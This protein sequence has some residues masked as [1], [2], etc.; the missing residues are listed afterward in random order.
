LGKKLVMHQ[1]LHVKE[2][3]Q[4]CL[5]IW[6]DFPRFL[7]VPNV[8]S[9]LNSVSPK[10]CC[11]ISY[12]SWPSYQ[13]Y[14]RTWCKNVAPSTHPLHN[15]TEGQTRL[16]C[17]SAHSRPSQAAIHSSGMWHQEMLPS[18]LHGCHFDTTSSFSTENFVPDIFD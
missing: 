1:T 17:R 18:I 15:M 14:G 10:A 13:V 2:S 4:H 11:S 8:L 7:N 3:N 5:D 9:Q 6:P 16:H 12:V